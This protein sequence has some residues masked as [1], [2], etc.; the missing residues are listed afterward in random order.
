MSSDSLEN[1]R[2]KAL[3]LLENSPHS[4]AALKRKLFN[5]GKFTAQDIK[6]VIDDLL[7]ARLLD[8]AQ[9]AANYIDYLK[10]TGIGRFKAVFKLKTKGVPQHIIQEAMEKH[11][12]TEE[13]DDERAAEAAKIKW[14]SLKYKKDW[15]EIKKLQAIARFLANR[16]FSMD[17]IHSV[18]K[19]IKK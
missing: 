7:K 1:C 5:A 9:F 3:R 6:T 2:E 16:G 10:T 14:R 13:S 19:E 18:V 12:G 4:V 11:W 17:I 15:P 8:D